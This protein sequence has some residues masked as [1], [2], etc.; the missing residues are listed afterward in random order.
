MAQERMAIALIIKSFKFSY[1]RGV[2]KAEI[3]IYGGRV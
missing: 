2:I 3:N 1:R